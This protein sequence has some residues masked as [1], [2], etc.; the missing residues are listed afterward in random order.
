MK[1]VTSAVAPSARLLRLADG[2][3]LAYSDR[4]DPNGYPLVLGH[5]MPGCHR[6]GTFFHERA[7]H[8]GFRILTPDRPGIGASDARPGQTL[9]DYPDDLRQLLD[10][11]GI[12]RFSHIG[13]SSGGSR[14]LAC[15]LVLADRLDL[16]VCLSG[17]THFAEY[18]GGLRL[19]EGTRWPGPR[20]ARLSPTLVRLAVTL[21]A[22]LS[23]RHPGLYLR[24]AR[25]LVSEQDRQLLRQALTGEIFR[26]DQLICLN[27][28]GRAIANDLLAELNDWGFRLAWVKRPI[29]LY[30]GEQDPFVAMDYAR[31]LADNLAHADL[32]R[33][34]EAGHL[35]PL[36]DTFQDHLFQRLRRALAPHTEER[37]HIPCPTR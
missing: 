28:G 30:Q 10:H 9:R 34:P 16:G 29:W 32:T 7:R 12:D 36:S 27:S 26:Q 19:I 18:P 3:R 20:L 24:Q 8:H 14:T 6:E 35:Y 31:H 22:A 25:H 37:T 33:L 5:G 21:V 4:G 15:A 11:L 2:R 23:R 13:W 1:P 17:Y